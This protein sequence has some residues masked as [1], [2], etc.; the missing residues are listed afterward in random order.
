[1]IGYQKK[2]SDYMPTTSNIIDGDLIF[3]TLFDT[4]HQQQLLIKEIADKLEQVE[5]S[6][7]GS[8]NATISDYES[9]KDYERNTLVVD[10]NTETVYR[11]LRAYKSKTVEQDC[12]DANLKLVGFESQIVTFNGNPTQSQ[13]NVLPEDTLVAIYSASDAPYQPNSLE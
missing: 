9:N 10:V 4:I 12:I 5:M 6:G 7:G 13:I 11:V 2:G 1:M 3:Q 8:G